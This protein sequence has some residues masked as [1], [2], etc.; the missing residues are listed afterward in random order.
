MKKIAFLFLSVWFTGCSPYK[1]AL[2]HFDSAEYEPAVALFKNELK[3]AGADAGELNFK[4]AESYRLSNRLAFAYPFYKA[5]KKAGFS[6]ENLIFY[7]AYAAKSAGETKESLALF[8]NYLAKGS[9]PDFR[10]LARAEIK[11]AEITDK[12]RQAKSFTRN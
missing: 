8:E 9:E 6:D 3:K 1:K 4:I 7:I 2:D 12:I 5:A 10:D 11:N